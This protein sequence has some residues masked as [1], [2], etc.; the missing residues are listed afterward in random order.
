MGVAHPLPR[1]LWKQA[2]QGDHSADGVS[3]ASVEGQL[4]QLANGEEDKALPTYVRGHKGTR[5]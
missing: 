5:I 2:Q 1:P 4:Q 3:T